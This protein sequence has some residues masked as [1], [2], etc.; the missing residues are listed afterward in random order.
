MQALF[1]AP[2]KSSQLRPRLRLTIPHLAGTAKV[3][4]ITTEVEINRLHFQAL[5]ELYFGAIIVGRPSPTIRSLNE[6]NSL[7]RVSRGIMSV[8]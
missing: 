4:N 5:I 3:F 6:L 2:A 7:F 8:D 1:L